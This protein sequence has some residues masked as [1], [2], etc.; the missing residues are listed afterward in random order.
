MAMRITTSAVLRNY[1]S[2][3]SKSAIQ[4]NGDRS[5]VLSQRSFSTAAE[6]PAAATQAYR[7]R[8]SYA[9]TCDYMANTKD[10][11]SK[12]DTIT[13]SGLEMSTVAKSAKAL[14][15]KAINGSTSDEGR[16]TIADSLRG[17][18]E[19]LV[20]SANAKYGDDFMFGGAN[21]SEAPFELVN[22]RVQFFGI[23]VN[24]SDTTEQATLKKWL[25]EEVL[26]DL[27]FGLEVDDTSK[28]TS[29]TAFCTSAS[30][31]DALGYG[32][33]SEGNDNNI[34]NILG[35]IADELEADDFDV[36]RTSK[37]S[38]K[39]DSA[40]SSLMNFVTELGT[41]SN[42]LENTL[43]RLEANKTTL[44]EKITAVESIDLAEAITNYS[45]SQYAY[46]AALKVGTSILSQSFIDYMN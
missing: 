2:G 11:I 23:D 16:Q 5:K 37:L 45:W 26:V 22:G 41:K 46:N 1:Q 20:L 4:L 33:D 40:C 30:G 25:S 19:T 32:V 29:G 43:S 44:N 13:S 7:L 36:E 17:Y 10:A 38:V 12:L 3:L 6:D 9:S 31:L 27:G 28:V 34:I 42:Y 15:L 39:F 35:Q 24:S 18:Q 14:I 8:K 21:N